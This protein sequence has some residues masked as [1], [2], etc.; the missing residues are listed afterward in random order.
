LQRII[1]SSKIQ[2]NYRITLITTIREKL[3]VEVGDLI[4]FV[5]DER[6]DI[7]LRKGEL[8]PL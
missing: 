3:D 6:G 5:E 1:G 2:P 4:L 7:I 8:K